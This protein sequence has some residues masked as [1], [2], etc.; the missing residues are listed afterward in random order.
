MKSIFEIKF[1]CIT[2]FFINQ[3]VCFAQGS[4]S[5]VDKKNQDTQPGFYNAIYTSID[6]KNL[7]SRNQISTDNGLNWR[8]QA[9]GV[10]NI[11]FPKKGSR[12][13]PVTSI[14]D[15]NRNLFVTFFNVLENPN[16]N[17]KVAEPLEA[18]RE[19]FIKY[20]VSEDNGITWINDNQIILDGDYTSKNP[21]PNVTI[22]E[23]AYYLGDTGSRALILSDGSILLPLQKTIKP[24]PG[25][26]T[27]NKLY[28]PTGGHTYTSVLMIKGTWNGKNIKWKSVSEIFGDSTKSTRGLIEPTIIELDNGNILSIMRG[29]NGGESDPNY[30]LPSYKW[31]SYSKDRGLTW[32][33]VIPWTYDNGQTFYSAS[34][35]SILHKH[36]NGK[37]VWIGNISSNN[38]KGGQPRYPLVMGLVDENNMTLI[39]KSIIILDDL[40]IEDKSKGELDLGHVSILEDK[41]SKELIIVY[42][43]IYGNRVKRDW[44]ILRVK[45]K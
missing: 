45:V 8:T 22:G 32:S 35:M 38:A 9:T 7:R 19:Y 11:P 15:Y 28:N 25:Q 17:S 42:P 34:S 41:I 3:L 29:S 1:Y 27:K 33:N 44:S 24:I 5:I 14:F 12:I 30:I 26:K 23:N 13:T 36:S 40:K 31:M 21:L 43:R 16:V 2:F 18:Q 6:D 37:I 10:K 4:L 20:R 39:K